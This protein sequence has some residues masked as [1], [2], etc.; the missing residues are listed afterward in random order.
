MRGRGE[1]Q[2]IGGKVR[3]HVGVR[4]V[5]D[6]SET[7]PRAR[8]PGRAGGF[9]G[10]CPARKAARP[11]P[12]GTARRVRRGSSGKQQTC[13][14][15]ETRATAANCGLIVSRKMCGGTGTELTYSARPSLWRLK[16]NAAP[17]RRRPGGSTTP[18]A[19]AT[20][21]RLRAAVDDPAVVPNGRMPHAIGSCLVYAI[22]HSPHGVHP[23]AA[24]DRR[25]PEC[26]RRRRV[27]AAH[28]RAELHAGGAWHDQARTDVD[29]ILRLLLSFGADPNQR[30]IN[31]YT[32]LHMAVAERNPLAVQI[33]LDGGADPELRTRIDEC[34][35]PLEM[36]EAAGLADIAAMLA[37]RGQPASPTAAIGSDAARGYAR[38][39]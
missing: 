6:G 27:P 24:G 9:A 31:D 2:V 7:P 19:G 10:R 18:F 12:S 15:G 21:T 37:R 1:A 20:W 16:R 25:R 8:V 34:E 29:D 17:K 26:A 35:T 11:G 5:D 36:A 39:R 28:C 38:P 14:V 30:G 13:A 4:S 23:D 33:L 3:S 32:P 22:Y